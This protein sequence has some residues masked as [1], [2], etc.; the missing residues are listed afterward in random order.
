VFLLVGA[1]SIKI[2]HE[3]QS[4]QSKFC[5]GGLF[6]CGLL[7]AGQYGGKKLTRVG[8]LFS[9]NIFR[10]AGCHDLAAAVAAFRPE[11]DDPVGGLDNFEVV[12]DDHDR[13]AVLDQLVQH[14]QQLGNVVEV[15][16]GRRFVEQ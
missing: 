2:S 11:V 4:W 16:A 15:Q 1:D 12:L 10:R 8:T 3:L 7:S 9:R 14:F 6:C 5:S 13:V